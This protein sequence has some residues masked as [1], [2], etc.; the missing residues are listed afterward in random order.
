MGV[1]EVP[2]EPPHLVGSVVTVGGCSVP[3]GPVGREEPARVVDSAELV[4]MRVC[5]VRVGQAVPA[6]RAAE[7][8][9]VVASEA[10]AAFCSVPPEPMGNSGP[11]R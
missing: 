7:L 5:S 8:L 6:A 2:A 11:A 3:A 9:A 10:A 1:P 4:V